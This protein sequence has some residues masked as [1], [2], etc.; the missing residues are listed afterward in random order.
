MFLRSRAC[1]DGGSRTANTTARTAARRVSEIRLVES[2]RTI[3]LLRERSSMTCEYCGAEVVKRNRRG[4][5]AKMGRVEHLFVA[6]KMEEK[7]LLAGKAIPGP[8]KAHIQRLSV[9]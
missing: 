6:S 3:A 9:T 2:S 1:I 7:M 5:S 4:R 8:L